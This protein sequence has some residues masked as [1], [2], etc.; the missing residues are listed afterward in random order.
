MRN[1]HYS[2]HR[3]S[4]TGQTTGEYAAFKSFLQAVQ[5]G[6]GSYSSTN[7]LSTSPL[8]NYFSYTYDVV[9]DNGYAYY[10]GLVQTALQNLGYNV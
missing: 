5:N 8:S 4:L 7:G 6:T 10:K 1:D 3:S 2:L 9:A